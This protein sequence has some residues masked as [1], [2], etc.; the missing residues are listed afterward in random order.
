MSKRKPYQKVLLTIAAINY[1]AA[2]G[3]G[4]AAALHEGTAAEGDPILASL[5]ASVV[6]FAGVGIVVHVIAS[7][8][9]P[10]LKV[11]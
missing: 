1:L 10:N 7:G 8:N 4:I 11:E 5:M 6:F 3:C 9:L 2:L